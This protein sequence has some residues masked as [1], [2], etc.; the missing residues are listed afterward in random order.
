[1]FPFL[2][3]CPSLW[4]SKVLITAQHSDFRLCFS[5]GKSQ[6]KWRWRR[7]FFLPPLSAPIPDSC[8]S[9]PHSWRRFSAGHLRRWQREHFSCRQTTK[10]QTS[11][12][13]TRCWIVALV[14]K[15]KGTNQIKNSFQGLLLKWDTKSFRKNFQLSYVT[16][17]EN[18]WAPTAN[19]NTDLFPA[20]Q[21]SG[22]NFCIY[23]CQIPLP[24]GEAGKPGQKNG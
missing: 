6:E 4:V 8:K 24:S 9:I 1:M 12:L 15:E 2:R 7:R 23:S 20:L 18:K 11:R 19:E 21:V 17:I 5:S 16:Q 14:P 22:S 10:I 3:S 13:K